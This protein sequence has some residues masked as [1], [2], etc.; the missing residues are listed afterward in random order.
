MTRR[1]S[2]VDMAPPTREKL[3]EAAKGLTAHEVA[4]LA[5]KITRGC[6]WSGSSKGSI[7]ESFTVEDRGYAGI[8]RGDALKLLILLQAAPRRDLKKVSADI[9]AKKDRDRVRK[10]KDEERGLALEERFAKLGLRV[11]YHGTV[12]QMSLNFDTGDRIATR[13]ETLNDRRRD[14]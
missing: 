6:N 14:R 3:M 2:A 5:N 7:T 9:Q 1:R 10:V 4:K 12:G 8:E 13:L 11:A